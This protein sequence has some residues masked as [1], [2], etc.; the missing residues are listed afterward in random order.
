M[1]GSCLGGVGAVRLVG[2]DDERGGEEPVAEDELGGGHVDLD[3]G[4]EVAPLLPQDVGGAGGN[5]NGSMSLDYLYFVLVLVLLDSIMA[6]SGKVSEHFPTERL[7]CAPART[8]VVVSAPA[9]LVVDIRAL[10]AAAEVEVG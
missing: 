5:F 4:D 6:N 2:G 3:D 10:A 1:F 9:G 8:F 7:N